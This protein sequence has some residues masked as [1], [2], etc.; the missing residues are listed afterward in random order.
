MGPTNEGPGVPV[1][2]VDMEISALFS[3]GRYRSVDV[4]G[5]LVVSD[6]LSTLTWRQGFKTPQFAKGRKTTIEAL[7]TICQ[8]I[9]SST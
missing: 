4:A 9:D 7:I 1:L 5:V 2:G 6:E 8:E 3:I